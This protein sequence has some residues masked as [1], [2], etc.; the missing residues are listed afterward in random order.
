MASKY[1][2][3]AA[4]LRRQSQSPHTMS[5]TDI[6]DLIGTP[7]PESS[8]TH[9]AWRGNDRSPDSTHSQAKYGWLAVGWEVKSVDPNRRSV[10]F[11]K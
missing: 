10:T 8:Y 7:P 9:N 6:E 2:S 11:R 5:F 1:D 4:H 3:L